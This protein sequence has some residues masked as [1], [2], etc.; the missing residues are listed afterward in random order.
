MGLEYLKTWK[1]SKEKLGGGSCFCPRSPFFFLSQQ[2]VV[3]VGA[4]TTITIEAL[5]SNQS[6]TFTSSNRRQHGEAPPPHC[7]HFQLC[8]QQ[9]IGEGVKS[10]A[11]CL[12]LC[13]L[14]VPRIVVA[15]VA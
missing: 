3:E 5:N 14:L 13:H 4:A 10:S 6:G 2:L 11:P 7:C 12:C 15:L 8:P 9:Q 1:E